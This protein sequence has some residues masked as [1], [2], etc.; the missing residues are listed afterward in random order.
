MAVYISKP[1]FSRQDLLDGDVHWLVEL[2]TG[3]DK[4]TLLSR[5]PLDV[6]S[7]EHGTMQFFGG[8]D[9]I[10]YTDE[11]E[12]FTVGKTDLSFKITAILPYDI[13]ELVSKGLNLTTM[14]CSIS[15]WLEGTDYKDRVVMVSD[16][17]VRDPSFGDKDE[18][19]AFGVRTTY[20]DDVT[21]IPPRDAR[22]SVYTFDKDLPG[23]D[24]RKRHYGQAYPWVL[25]RPGYSDTSIHTFA[26]RAILRNLDVY[27]H[28]WPEWIVAGHECVPGSTVIIKDIEDRKVTGT[29]PVI[30]QV[31]DLGQTIS[32]AKAEHFAFP[33]G[34]GATMTAA[35]FDTQY[36]VKWV[37]GGGVPNDER[38]AP[39]RGGGDILEYLIKLADDL[40]V[41]LGRVNAA[42]R[43]LNQFKFDFCLDQPAEIWEIIKTHLLPYMPVTLAVS[44]EGIYP[45]AWN[46]ELRNENAVA[47]IDVD[48]DQFERTSMVDLEFL[49]RSPLNNFSMNYAKRWQSGNWAKLARMSGAF[50][51]DDDDK[52]PTN[53]NEA[54][55]LYCRQSRTRYGEKD[56]SIDALSIY[57]PATAFQTLAWW[58][59]IYTLPAYTVEYVAP[60][61]WGWLTAGSI[62]EFTDTAIGFS[63]QLAIVQAIE[64][65]DDGLIG[66]RLTWVEDLPRDSR[67]FGT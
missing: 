61:Y 10:K 67:S 46:R 32:I 57:D 12:F 52:N 47:S 42:K 53:E 25:G 30:Q 55:S 56:K 35:N 6:P 2:D 51:D 11:V 4:K 1:H 33:F 39:I 54:L 24:T 15:R 31:D 29:I 28:P 58:S 50:V 13:V 63:N 23:R 59:R 41:D 64:W 27:P 48:R 14:R 38:T 37:T 7:V 62:V 44:G 26:S 34:N 16:Q 65:S 20:T 36:I 3:S 66:L 40:Q 9:E 19:I 45:I 43:I 5:D 18:P 8:L 21:T 60:D 17:M 22:T 49:G